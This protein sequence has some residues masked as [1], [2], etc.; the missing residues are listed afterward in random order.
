MPRFL[1]PVLL[2][3]LLLTACAP[4]PAPAPTAAPP[5]A[6]TAP[7]ATAAPTT[8]PTPIASVRAVPRFGVEFNR[9][10]VYAARDALA[11]LPQPLV[12]FNP[13][14]WSTVEPSPG[15]R[16]W[17]ALND[18]ENEL[19][20]I[21]QAGG[22]PMVIV[23]NG[24]PEWAR[25]IPASACGPLKPEAIPAF[26]AFVG[27]LVKRYSAPPFNVRYW[28]LGNEPDAAYQI[29][30]SGMPFGCWGDQSDPDY[31]GGAYAAMLKVVYPVIKAADPQ[32][33]VI[34]GGLLLD[35]DPGADAAC[36]SGRFFEGVLKSG[37]GDAFD[38]L[39][40]HSYVYWDQEG[41]DWDVFHKVWAHRG[42]NLAGK[43]AFLRETMARYGV[44]KPLLMNEG[45]LLCY[46]SDPIC[47]P[48]GFYQ[49]QPVYAAKTLVRAH[50]LGLYGVIWYT[51]NGPGWQD[52]GLLDATQQPRPVF[53]TVRFLAAT[54]EGATYEGATRDGALE[55]HRFRK[56]DARYEILW[57][58]EG[59]PREVPLPA[60]ARQQLSL[61]GEPLPLGPQLV[62][63]LEPV[64][65]EAAAQ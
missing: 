22:V 11:D 52:A 35:C 30:A 25:A 28:E 49:A 1:L 13:V 45:A 29:V 18:Q 21:A 14:D 3:A 58:N 56:G 36:A 57:V 10:T 47:G 15:E 51:L 37:G 44:A 40:Y 50:E 24:M 31:G 2:L 38:I 32:A 42:G 17:I 61:A 46:K 20:S 54:L 19:K 63:G 7:A 16:N 64:I 6:P 39:A 26:A 8:G 34:L 59:Q 23:G 48:Q 62:V 60:G 4:A 5:T 55:T 43:A 41:R 12:R 9:Y 65:V 53:Q 27:E 33:Q